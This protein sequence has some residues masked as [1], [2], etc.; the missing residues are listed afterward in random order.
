V[1]GIVYY[2]SATGNG[3]LAAERLARLLGGERVSIASTRALGR[4]APPAR[5]VGLV[6]PAYF[7]TNGESG[8]PRMVEAFIEK[9]EGLEGKLIFAVATHGGV[10]GATIA[11]CARLIK[12]RGGEL[13]AGYALKIMSNA[14]GAGEKL[15]QFFLNKPIELADAAS[16]KETA[17]WKA[18]E[19]AWNEKLDAVA[20][21]ATEGRRGIRETRGIIASL[22]W[23][24]LVALEK[25]MFRARYESLS[26]LKSRPFRELVAAADRGFRLGAGC[27]GCGTCARVCP[28]GNI[29]MEGRAPSW[30]HGC[31]NCLACYQW[32]PQAAIGGPL[33]A[34]NPRYRHPDASIPILLGESP[35][36]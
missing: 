15:A 16:L 21:A 13:A 30:R 7:A 28:A 29:D 33:V 11:R 19:G 34:Y 24:P 9:L 31:E 2:F 36:K 32:C 4:I 5:I 1:D 26:G 18:H 25:L 27:T 6:F 10:P 35:Q 22:A 12:R 17:R 8:M 14:P 23:A 3:A 20:R